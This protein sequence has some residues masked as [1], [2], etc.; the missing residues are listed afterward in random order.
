MKIELRKEASV[1][2][3]TFEPKIWFWVY[4]DD[5]AYTCHHEEEK[6]RAHIAAIKEHY[7]KYGTPKPYVETLLSEEIHIPEN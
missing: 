6:A 7:S 1:D 3:E 4:L 5:S 2:K